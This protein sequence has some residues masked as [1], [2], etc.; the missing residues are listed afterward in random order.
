MVNA[1]DFHF[2][3]PEGAI[4]K[5]PVEPRR[6]ARMVVRS[7]DGELNHTTF[8]NLPEVLKNAGVDGLWANDTKVL[9]ARILASKTS[10][11]QIEIFLLAPFEEPVEKALNARQDVRWLAMVRNAKRWSDG[12]ATV[13]GQRHQLIIERLERREEGTH[14][15]KLSWTSLDKE[16]MSS[17]L[18]EVL[19]DLG[20]TPLPPYMRRQAMNQDRLDYQT[21]FAMVP[22]SVAAP[23][24]GLHFDVTLLANLASCD[25]T[26]QKLTLHVGAGT[27]KPLSE[28]QIVNHTMHAEQCIVTRHSIE[29]MVMQSKRVATGTTTLRVMES[30]YWWSLEHRV[31][32]Q[33]LEVLEQRSPFGALEDAAQCLNWTDKSALQHLL[34]H[35]P[36]D[37]HGELS[38]ETQLMIVPGYRLRMIV[39]LITNFHQPGSTLLCLVA[40]AI[41][42][43]GWK[44]LY[45]ACLKLDY[46]F[47][48]Y[49][50]GSLLW[51]PA[52]ESK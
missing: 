33:W 41:G 4:A 47:L 15:V 28:G 10:G 27:F 43:K 42:M 52:S 8:E 17:S 37:E 14:L 26:L 13:A 35:A 9:H 46:R 51:I 30:L 7:Q 40:A 39:G 18:S 25:L 38:F 22:G 49:G 1:S 12:R 36:W 19:D 5:H 11:G 6:S 45:Q 20:Q 2:D 50:D 32:G 29:S 31:N 44:D 24:A 23:T 16:T 21:V 3:L 34:D 48:S